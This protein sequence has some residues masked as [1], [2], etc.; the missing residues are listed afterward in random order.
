[1]L[2]NENK[3]LKRQLKSEKKAHELACNCIGQIH[4]IANRD[5]AEII[6]QYFKDMDKISKKP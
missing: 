4:D 3:L 2:K 6:K 5:V 1:M